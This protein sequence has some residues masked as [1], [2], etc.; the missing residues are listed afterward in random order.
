MSA[1][2]RTDTVTGKTIDG[3]VGIGI[4]SFAHGHANGYAAVVNAHPYATLVAI[5]DE[6][7]ERGQAAAEQFGGD[8]VADYHDVL[9]RDDIDAVIICSENSRHREMTVAAAE[10][11]K[12]VLCEKPLATSRADGLAMIAACQKHNVK[13]QTAFPVRFSAPTI[14]LRDAVVAGVVGTPLAVAARNPGTY[15]G[16]WF[17]DP[18]LAGGGAVID[19]TVHVADVLRWI[20][21]AEFTTVYAEV[22][23]RTHDIPVDDTGLLMLTMSNGL[24]VTLDTSWSRPDNYPI[25]GGVTIDVVGDQGVVSL[26]AFNNNVRVVE[27]RGPSN[28]LIPAVISGDPEMVSAFIDAVKHDTPVP[29]TGED[30][31]KAL[32]VALCAYESA[33]RGAPVPCPGAL[34]DKEGAS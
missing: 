18:T 8:Y 26:D 11:G 20:F 19:H 21:G 22:S 30:G 16:G 13:L 2:A 3:P 12:H 32:E 6:D 27:S 25:W 14:A 23:T 28:K 5:A 15:P 34:M 4:L 9:A 7:A 17:G 29:V 33:R 24:R 1:G 10:A 31:L